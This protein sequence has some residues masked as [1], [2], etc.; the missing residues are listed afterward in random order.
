[1]TMH[2]HG[3]F[4][5]LPY[6]EPF[7]VILGWDQIVTVY[8]YEN[9]Y[10]LVTYQ[11]IMPLAP[12]PDTPLSRIILTLSHRPLPY[13]NNA[14]DQARKRQVSLLTSSVQL[15]QGSKARGP[16]SNQLSLDSPISPNGRLYSS[17][18]PDCYKST[19]L[20]EYR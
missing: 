7:K 8:A 10:C 13:P 11:A 4:I 18:H 12:R 16:N 20:S 3:N 9:L 19:L 2:C 6:W 1:M 17:S 15:D 5:V 14:E